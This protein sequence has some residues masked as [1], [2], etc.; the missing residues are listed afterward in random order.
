[1]HYEKVDLGASSVFVVNHGTPNSCRST[2][3]GGA[4]SWELGKDSLSF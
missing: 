4:T 1:M 2:T 3:R